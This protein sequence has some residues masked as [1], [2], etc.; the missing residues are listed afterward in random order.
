[1]DLRPSS[2]HIWTHC[3][4]QP[5]MA[6]AVP[7]ELPGDPAREGTCAA[8]VAEMVL[9][10]AAPTCADL[11]GQ[12]HPNGWLV[13][14]DMTHRIQ[15][16]VDLLR[17]Y[18]GKLFVERK[19][20]L[21]NHIAG[22]PDAWGLV[23]DDHTLRADDLKYGF[24][25]VEPFRNPQVGIYAG[26]ILRH[27]TSR[28]V[29]VRRV[30][31]GIYQPRAYHPAGIHRTWV[32]DPETL[33]AFVQEIEE[34]GSR[35]QAPDAPATPG[36]HC[37][38]CPAAAT[39]PAVAHANYRVFDA[40]AVAQQRHMTAQEMVEELEFLRIAGDMLKGRTSAV[41]AEAE[42]RIHKGE[43]LPGWHMEQRAGQRRFKVPADVVRAMTG[44]NPEVAKM[45]TPAELERLGAD[46]AAVAH[47]TETPRTKPALRKIAPGYFKNLFK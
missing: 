34:A 42:A 27:L 41:H 16:Y 1:M 22:T 4:A 2:A 23:D 11:V 36:E 46:P 44:I 39:C 9:T 21:N 3:A 45:I 32:C 17:S 14:P 29:T 7:A 35:A 10:G 19:V 30:V 15:K 12:S 43:H 13:E 28:G 6:A 38:Y 26:S 24:N 5:R 18:G 33:M 40:V 25:V 8:W 37:E 31:I 20:R 47:M